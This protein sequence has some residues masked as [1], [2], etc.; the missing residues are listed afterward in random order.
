MR[1]VETVKRCGACDR[2]RQISIHAKPAG[3]EA[4][5]NRITTVVLKPEQQ[6]VDYL[7]LCAGT[8]VC[9]EGL[10]PCIDDE[11]NSTRSTK[12]SSKLL[13]NMTMVTREEGTSF[14]YVADIL[15]RTCWVGKQIE[16]HVDGKITRYVQS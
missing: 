2:L 11:S 12:R 14:G 9:G 15:V 16:G 6:V 10:E 13:K 1:A 5:I 7:F 4:D 8:D 3:T